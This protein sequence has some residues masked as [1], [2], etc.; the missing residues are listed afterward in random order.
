MWSIS[1]KDSKEKQR[2]IHCIQRRW[3]KP[4]FIILKFRSPRKFS[5]R[6]KATEG[7]AEPPLEESATEFGS[8]LWSRLQHHQ[9][10]RSAQSI[11]VQRKQEVSSPGIKEFKACQ[12]HHST[13]SWSLASWRRTVNPEPHQTRIL[14]YSIKTSSKQLHQTWPHL[15]QIQHFPTSTT[16]GRSSHRANPTLQTFHAYWL[17]LRWTLLGKDRRSR[18][19]Q[20]GQTLHR[21]VR[22]SEYQGCS[23]WLRSESHQRRLFLRIESIYRSSWNAIKDFKR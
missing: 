2:Q 18:W 5:N 23:S 22:A 16:Y 11:T 13:I 6:V 9:S 19:N 8:F 21:S 17:G 1:C 14:D 15:L 12:S 20:R 4:N 7:E 3:I 10:R